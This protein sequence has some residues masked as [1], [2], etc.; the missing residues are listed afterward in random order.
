M[1]TYGLL[2]LRFDK[3][4]QN[5]V[6]Q[7][8]FNLKINKFKKRERTSLNSNQNASG[9]TPLC[10]SHFS[11]DTGLLPWRQGLNHVGWFQ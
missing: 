10:L 4:Q 3:K 7:L 1:Y 6:K 5:S 2:M 11:T 8:F 9:T